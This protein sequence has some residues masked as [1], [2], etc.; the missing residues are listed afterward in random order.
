MLLT[1][2]F[3]LILHVPCTYPVHSLPVT[4]PYSACT[5][6]FGGSMLCSVF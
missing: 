6:H 3:A 2:Y 4:C 1:V 5:L